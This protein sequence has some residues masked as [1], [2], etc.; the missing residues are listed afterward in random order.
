MPGEVVQRFAHLVVEALQGRRRPEQLQ[1]F[2]DPGA[3]RALGTR[4]SVLRSQGIRLASVRAQSPRPGVAEVTLRLSSVRSN[5]AVALR[6]T[7]QGNAWRCTAL[8]IG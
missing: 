2:F 8:A 3:L 1:G 4:A 6:L 7:D 5:T